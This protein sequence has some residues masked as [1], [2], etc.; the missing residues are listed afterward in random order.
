MYHPWKIVDGQSWSNAWN[1]YDVGG[2]R[3]QRKLEDRVRGGVL[4]LRASVGS[5]HLMNAQ[6]GRRPH[7]IGSLAYWRHG[8]SGERQVG[9]RDQLGSNTR[10]H[11]VLS[12]SDA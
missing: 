10:P 8:V 5:A 11:Q 2:H 1:S 6:T 7:R 4:T 12:F 9:V 3:H